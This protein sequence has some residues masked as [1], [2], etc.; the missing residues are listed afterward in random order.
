[1]LIATRTLTLEDDRSSG[2]VVVRLFAPE[3]G[4]L[5]WSCQY[6]IQWPRETR[7]GSA[8]GI[9]AIQALD[10]AMRK[11][12]ADLYTSNPHKTGS[13]RWNERGRGYGFPVPAVLRDL[14]VGDDRDLI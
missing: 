2:A 4:T 6:E 3:K 11:I 13:L 1:M 12:G 7:K 14:L 5:D 10:L 9:D 8:T